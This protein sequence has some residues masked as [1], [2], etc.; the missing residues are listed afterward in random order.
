MKS[1]RNQQQQRSASNPAM[2]LCRAA[3]RVCADSLCNFFCFLFGY[4][5][6]VTQFSQTRVANLNRRAG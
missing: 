1:I 4:H 5:F 3:G 2:R 6:V